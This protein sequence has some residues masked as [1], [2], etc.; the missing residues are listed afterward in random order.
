MVLIISLC[1]QFMHHIQTNPCQNTKYLNT[2]QRAY[3][4][5]QVFSWFDSVCIVVTRW[6]NLKQ[7][8]LLQ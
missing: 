6:V 5:F 1:E 4:S 3:L 2:Q 7:K 8:C